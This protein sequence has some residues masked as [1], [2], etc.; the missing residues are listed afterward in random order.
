MTSLLNDMSLSEAVWPFF[1]SPRIKLL[2]GERGVRRKDEHRRN[3]NLLASC[4]HRQNS[5]IEHKMN[6]NDPEKERHIA[7][8]TREETTQAKLAASH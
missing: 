5:A 6:T 1:K 8:P 7:Y 2:P 3:T 4:E